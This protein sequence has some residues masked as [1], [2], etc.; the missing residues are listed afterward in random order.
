MKK[1]FIGM[2][3]L[4]SATFVTAQTVADA[5]SD[6]YYER[7]ETAKD[8]LMDVVA[9]HAASPDAWYWLGQ[10]Y[11]QEKKVDSG[12]KILAGKPD[13]FLAA[14]FS[15]KKNPLLFIGWAHVLLDSGMKAAARQQ[16]EDILKE[17][18]YKNAEVLLAVAKANIQS[19][20]GDTAWAIE[21]L[22][23]A[24]KRH[25]KN[26]AIY[27]ALGDAYTKMV[28]GSSAVKNYDNALDLNPGY[29]EA[30]YKKGLIYKTQKNTEIYLD[31]FTKAWEMD[32]AYAPALYE[33]YYYYYFRDVNRAADFLSAYIRHADPSPQHAYMVTD[34]SYVSQKYQQAV[35]QAKNIIAAED[36]SAK[37]RLYK[38]IAYSNAALGDSATALSNLDV[39]FE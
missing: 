8:K 3:L 37:P 26:A 32:T 27:V 24:V 16:M 22:N 15:K 21:P 9:Q 39:Y 5:E 23:R 29:A 19:K 35:D 25:K 31:R 14:G 12:W 17:T 11:L 30:M 18:K 13:S 1:L 6:I 10:I 4:S 33:L 34:L 20:Y 2:I 28:D 7:Y 36:D 38:L